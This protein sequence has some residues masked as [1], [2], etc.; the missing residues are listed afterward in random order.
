MSTG[1]EAVVDFCRELV[2]QPSLPGQER[3]VAE[4]VQD[5]MQALD[6]DHVT[7]DTWGNVVG[8]IVG[9]KK[10]ANSPTILLDAH[11]DTVPPGNLDEWQHDPFGAQVEQGRIY[12]RGAADDKASVAAIISM[13][14]LLDRSRLAGTI[15]VSASVHEEVAEGAALEK[16]VESTQPDFV[17]IC[18]PTHLKLG[19]GQK[20]RA[21]VVVEATGVTSHSSRPADGLNAVYKI[22]PAL[23]RLRSV[24]TQEDPSLG[25]E[26]VELVELISTPFPSNAMVPYHCRARYDCRLIRQEPPAQ[27]LARLKAAAGEEVTVGIQRQTITCYTGAQIDIEEHYPAWT[28]DPSAPL[29]KAARRGLET[30]GHWEGTCC[31]PYCT[32]ASYTAGVAHIPTVL[33]GPG[34]IENAHIVDEYVDITQLMAATE[35]YAAIVS[36]VLLD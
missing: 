31:V 2:R 30:S 36:A 28:I 24:E 34:A 19:V 23:E 35:A 32:N 16:V 20:G 25:E 21:G 12:G 15:I 33:Y 22:L 3:K 11:M 17:V 5:R 18:E 14:A 1:A 27:L 8:T 7:V 4:V 29:V 6:F 26:I 13:A 10:G 9:R